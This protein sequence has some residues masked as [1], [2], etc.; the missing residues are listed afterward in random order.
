MIL[1][2]DRSRTNWPS[3]YLMLALIAVAMKILV[4]PGFMVGTADAG[5][6]AGYP[7]VICT[8]HGPATAPSDAG[9]SQIT[10]YTVTNNEGDTCIQ[11]SDA[12][13][14]NSCTFEGPVNSS[15]DMFFVTATNSHGTGAAGTSTGD[16]DDFNPSQSP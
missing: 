4:P 10:G 5:G 7:L 9:S 8:G 14:S 16:D 11:D 3:V 13:G 1:A 6:R 2:R 12:L 15:T